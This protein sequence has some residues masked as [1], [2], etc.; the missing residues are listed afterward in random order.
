MGSIPGTA[1][2]QADY[3]IILMYNRKQDVCCDDHSGDEGSGMPL[4]QTEL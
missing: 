4:G 2:G 3:Y 1:W